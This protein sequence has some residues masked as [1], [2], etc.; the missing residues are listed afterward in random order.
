M[1]L[2]IAMEWENKHIHAMITCQPDI[3][4]TTVTCVQHSVCPAENY[5]EVKHA[6]KHLLVTRKDG[7]YHWQVKPVMALPEHPIPSCC[8]TLHGTL[9]TPIRC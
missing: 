3:S 5:Q 1:D 9:N 7:I 6:I 8:A 4:A 2:D